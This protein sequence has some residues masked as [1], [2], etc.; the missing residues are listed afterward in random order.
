MRVPV[1]HIF[2]IPDEIESE[3]AAPLLTAG[4]A[5]YAP[6]KKYIRYPGSVVGVVGIGGLGH[7]AIQFASKMGAE[8]VAISHSPSKKKDALKLGAS[9]F[10][11][12]RDL[13]KLAGS[14]DFILN[15]VSVE[16]D[17]T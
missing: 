10:V 8:V 2:P 7:L 17:Y 9:H 11:L 6:L 14:I 12:D 16:N 13:D 3:H 1:R 4:H 5:V 15:T